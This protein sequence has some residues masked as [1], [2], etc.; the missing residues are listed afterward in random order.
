MCMYAYVAHC[1]YTVAA[2]VSVTSHRSCKTSCNWAALKEHWA[3]ETVRLPNPDI[4]AHRPYHQN[5]EEQAGVFSTGVAQFTPDNEHSG[6]RAIHCTSYCWTPSRAGA[7]EAHCIFLLPQRLPKHN[8]NS[9]NR[10]SPIKYFT[11]VKKHVMWTPAI[12]A[13]V[14]FPPYTQW[15]EKWTTILDTIRTAHTG[16]FIGH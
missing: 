3:R 14:F 16:D 9:P 8:T 7:T 4:I 6:S 1:F 2:A 10:S 13:V 15:T 11:Y 12:S 5:T